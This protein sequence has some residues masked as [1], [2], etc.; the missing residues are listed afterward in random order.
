MRSK[1]DI[2]RLLTTN[3]DFR[4]LWSAQLISLG[5]DWF[6]TVALLG[7]VLDLTGSA[8]NAGMILAASILPQFLLSPISGSFADRFDRKRLM[9]AT[10]LLRMVL[11][12]GM[13]LVR[14]PE[15]VWI[16][17]FCLAGMSAL[18][19]FFQ[20]ASGASLPNLVAPG[21]LAA[22]NTLTSASW[23][24]ML[25][26]G[27]AL[28]GLVAGTLGREAAFVIDAV[29]FLVSALLVVRI[30]AD[31]S[32]RRAPGQV[33]ARTGHS[34]REGFAYARSD[35]RV[36]ALLASKGGFGLGVGVVALL[37]VFATDVFR[38]GDE[39]I[40]LLF[41]ARGVGALLGPFLAIRYV[42]DDERR[43]LIALAA[44]IGIYGLCYLALA[45]APTLAVAAG[46]GVVAHLGG[47]AQWVLSSYGLQRI[48]PDYVRG[49]VLALDLGLVSLSIGVSSVA[50]GRLADMGHP[51]TVMAGLAGLEILYALG[52]ALFTRK[53]WAKKPAGPEHRPKALDRRID[54]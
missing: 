32:Q 27:A 14:S 5:G 42:R 41:A 9:V 26:V 45:A 3:S 23:G 16:G 37:P 40:G 6:T 35:S 48:V 53:M 33:A 24:T 43:L 18:S 11:A 8:L 28:G 31:F 13:L 36:L 25:A 44:S 4:K 39:G 54:G 17:L 50:A 19:A 46:I 51:R 12:L 52:F 20:P 34:I 7:L 15:T 49:R 22:A 38:A 47:G 30:R 29:S 10:D 1:G 2:R 21:D